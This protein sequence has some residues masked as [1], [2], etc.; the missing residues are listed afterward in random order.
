MQDGEATALMLSRRI[1]TTSLPIALRYA[2]KNSRN[3]KGTILATVSRSR[4]SGAIRTSGATA[5]QQPR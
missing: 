3:Q 2:R 1:T 5:Q 4:D